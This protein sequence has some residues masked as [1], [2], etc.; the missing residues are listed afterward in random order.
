M[1]RLGPV[2]VLMALPATAS[3]CGACVQSFEQLAYPAL[4]PATLLLFVWRIV[5][6]YIQ[7]RAGDKPRSGWIVWSVTSMILLVVLLFFAA[8]GGAF[9]YLVLSFAAALWLDVIGHRPIM[10]MGV[11]RKGFFKSSARVLHVAALAM[12]MALSAEGYRRFWLM[13]DFDRM[14]TCVLP[15]TG[16]ARAMSNR[17]ATD[18]KFDVERLVPLIA[19]APSSDATQAFDVL[20]ARANAKDLDVVGGTLLE[21]PDDQL[22]LR[23][24]KSDFCLRQWLEGL[25]APREVGPEVVRGWIGERL[26][27]E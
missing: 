5:Y 10:A 1:G 21:L 24:W 22:D 16:P 11:E 2:I 7:V 9:F 6:L 26:P 23:G 17:I 20:R 27:K 8:L 3:A 13:D 12:L 25:D 18:T 14:R 15:G 4:V 19:T